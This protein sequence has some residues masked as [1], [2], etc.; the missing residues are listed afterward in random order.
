MDWSREPRS[1]L[2]IYADRDLLEQILGNLLRN[3][4]QAL[5]GVERPRI[6]WGLGSLETGRV[7][8]SIED[9][10]PGISPEVRDKLFTPF[11][12]TKAQGTGLG[13]SFVKKVLEDH[14]GT[15]QYVE[16]P[17]SSG[18]GARF[19]LMMPAMPVPPAFVGRERGLNA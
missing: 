1:H 16:R 6:K 7:W 9:N 11:V 19:E 8:L 4:L 17:L 12:T 13:L 18:R 5:E 2:R 3:A 10:G 14:G 15:I